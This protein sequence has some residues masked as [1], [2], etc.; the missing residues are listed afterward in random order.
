MQI[1]KRTVK[2]LEHLGLG[3]CQAGWYRQKDI[4]EVLKVPNDKYVCGV[5]CIGYADGQPTQ[6]PRRPLEDMV[7]YQTWGNKR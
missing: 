6:R 4:R 2:Y 5:I 3:T 7:Y 1:I